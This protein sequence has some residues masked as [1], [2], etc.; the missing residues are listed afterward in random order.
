MKIEIL[1]QIETKDYILRFRTIKIE[2]EG[3][4]KR[5][6]IDS[7]IFSGDPELLIYANPKATQEQCDDFF[8]IMHS[9]DAMH[10]LYAISCLSYDVFQQI[11]FKPNWKKI[12]DKF[13]EIGLV[14]LKFKPN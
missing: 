11:N 6:F 2:E 8:D 5:I 7:A 12:W 13:I 9:V 10:L 14:Q 1:D 3:F 4:L